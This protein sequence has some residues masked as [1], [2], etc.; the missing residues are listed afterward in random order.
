MI[1]ARNG[2]SMSSA[3]KLNIPAAKEP[4]NNKIELKA[5]M[6]SMSESELSSVTNSR[7]VRR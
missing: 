1:E 4:L 5:R 3:K 2:V 7:S 6:P